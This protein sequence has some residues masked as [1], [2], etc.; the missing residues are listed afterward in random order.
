MRNKKVGVAVR[1]AHKE[2]TSDPGFLSIFYVS[3]AH[4]EKHLRGYDEEDIPLP[5]MSTGILQFRYMVTELPANGKL[6]VLRHHWQGNL[7]SV[8]DSLGTWSSQSVSHRRLEIRKVLE[9]LTKYTITACS[10]A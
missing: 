2:M 5:V 9:N 8:V 4:Y 1:K 7:T 3:S 6:N 10:I